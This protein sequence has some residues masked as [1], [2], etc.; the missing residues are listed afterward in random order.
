[1]LGLEKISY[2]DV[3]IPGL[4]IGARGYFAKSGLLM[5]FVFEAS[6]GPGF[7]MG[8]GFTLETDSWLGGGY[9]LGM[10]AF[11]SPNQAVELQ[12]GE[13]GFFSDVEFPAG[14]V[15]YF[16]TILKLNFAYYF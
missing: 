8:D 14:T 4:R 15:N 9:G 11:I 2:K 12:F 10:Q 6:H 13:Q 5:P 1:M 3:E 16:G 7:H